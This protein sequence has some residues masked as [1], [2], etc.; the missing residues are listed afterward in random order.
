M[1]LS[2]SLC[3]AAFCC[4]LY[5]LRRDSVSLGLPLAYLFG[6][7][8]IHVPGAFAH[9]VGGDFLEDSEVTAMGIRLTAFGAAAYVCGVWGAHKLPQPRFAAR[10]ADHKRFAVFCL[11]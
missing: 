4:L 2:I 5:L 6:L 8:L 1:T 7:L 9:L 11:G 3:L 10:S